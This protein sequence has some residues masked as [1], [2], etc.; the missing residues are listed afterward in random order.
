MQYTFPLMAWWQVLRPPHILLNFLAVGLC[1]LP[2]TLPPECLGGGLC[3]PFR[4][5]HL[6]FRGGFAPQTPLRNPGRARP[7]LGLAPA[8][9]R[10]M[11]PMG[12]LAFL[13]LEAVVFI[14]V[15][16]LARGLAVLNQPPD[17]L[18]GF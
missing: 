16:L 10:Y 3:P 6:N 14:G 12:S 18:E 17:N 9:A 2:P 13:Y 5:L 15:L 1:P 7:V 11:F 8:H 4:P